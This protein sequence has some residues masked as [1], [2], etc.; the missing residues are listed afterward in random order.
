MI[1]GATGRFAEL[2]GAMDRIWQS[3]VKE[4]Q[5]SI[6][7]LLR[8]RILTFGILL[9]VAFL[10]LVSLTISASTYRLSNLCGLPNPMN[11][12]SRGRRSTSLS[13]LL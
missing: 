6:W 4:Y 9:A 7:Y 1:F 10:L 8:R 12:K 13:A 3:P 11:W 2:Q 5:A